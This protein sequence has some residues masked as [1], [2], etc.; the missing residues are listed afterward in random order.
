MNKTEETN[1]RLAGQNV[2]ERDYWLEKLA[3]E[4]VKTTFPYDH[5]KAEGEKGARIAFQLTGEVFD[6]LVKISNRSQPRLH[7]LL[8]AGWLML[9]NKYTG[10]SDIIVGVPTYKQDVEGELINTV[11]AV[12]SS[13]GG[14]MTVKELLMQVGKTMLEADKNQ[15]YP[16]ETLV[17]KLDIAGSGE[18][19][20]LFDLS[21][22]LEGIHEKRYLERISQNMVVSFRQ[23][24][25][26]LEG[27]VEYNPGL[28]R[29]ETIQRIV[30]HYRQLMQ[31]AL[32]NVNLPVSEVSILSAEER[33]QVCEEFNDN[34]ADYYRDKSIYRLVEERAAS[35]PGEE[36]LSFTGEN[37]TYGE[38]NG[39]AN[40]LAAELIE[41][42][43][44]ADDTVAIL[45]KRGPLMV[46]SILAIWKA[47]GAYI[48]LDVNYPPPRVL[49]ILADSGTRNLLASPGNIDPQLAREYGGIIIDPAALA[50]G[51]SAENISGEPV[52]NIRG[53][54]ET[55]PGNP[56]IEFSM[57]SLAYIIYTSGST[58]KPKGAMVE[59]A[60]M[61]N[62]MQSKINLLGIDNK[63]IVAQNASHTFDIS[64]WQFFVALAEGGK[65]FIYPDNVILDP[66]TFFKQVIENKITI[67]EVV[68]S[69]LSVML[70]VVE[71]TGTPAGV[72]GLPLPID[73]LLVTGEEVKPY[74]MA[75]WF[76]MYPQIKVVNAY[77][78]TEASDDITHYVMTG[79]AD[80][81]RERIPIGKTVQNL[82][83]H[84]VDKY[85]NLCPI[86]VV[87][88]LWVSGIGVGRGYLNRPELTAERFSETGR[89]YA[90]LP[91]TALQIK[92]FGGVGTALIKPVRDGRKGSDPPEA[93]FYRTG[94]L[95]RWLPDG[96]ID[97]LGRIDYQVKIRGY[98]IE[99][100]EIETCLATHQQVKEAI[101]IDRE[102][103][104]GKKYLCAYLVNWAGDE[105]LPNTPPLREYLLNTLPDYMVPA[106]FVI[107]KKI[108]LTPNGKVDRKALPKP[109]TG[110]GRGLSYISA[111]M[112]DYLIARLKGRPK[113]AGAKTTETAPLPPT[114]KEEK[115]TQHLLH[116]FNDTTAEYPRG[117]TL[118]QLFE[119]QVERTPG[120][121]ALTGHTL[122]AG[123]EELS[124]TYGEFNGR[125]NRLAR[126]LR[127]KGV[128]ADSIVG[129]MVERTVEMMVGIMGILKSGGAYMAISHT[130][131]GNRIEFM[132]GDS[133][134]QVL[135]TDETRPMPGSLAQ[136]TLDICE[137]ANYAEESRNLPEVNTPGNLAAVFYTSGSTGTPKGVLVEHSGLVNRI[138]WMQRIYPIGEHD[139]IMQKTSVIFDVSVWELFSWS[140][141]GAAL[142]LLPLGQ[143]GRQ[144]EVVE[145]IKKS[146]VTAMH[147]TPTALRPFLRHV[148]ETVS[149]GEVVTLKRVFASGEVLP[150]DLVSQ[151]NRLLYENAGTRLYNLYG[152]TEAS[153]EVTYYEC[154]TTVEQEK[155]PI[156]KPIDN[157]RLYIVNPGLEPVPEGTAGQ[158]CI[159]G[160]ALARGYLNRPGLTK[161]IF[162]ERPMEEGGRLYLTGDLARRM[163]NGNIDF[164]GRIDHQVQINGIRIELEEIE[165]ILLKHPAIKE[166]VVVARYEKKDEPYL[167]AF[168]VTAD[169]L[170]QTELKEY[171]TRD[172]PYYSIPARFRQLE[173]VPLTPT[174][175]V[176]RKVL[177]TIDLQPEDSGVEYL[178]PKTELE[179]HIAGIWEE[180]LNVDKVGLND[181]FFDIGGNS[182]GLIQVNNKLKEV[183]QQDIPALM[184]FEYP[185]IASIIKY[186]EKNTA[187]KETKGD[188]KEKSRIETKNKG[189][190]KMQQRRSRKKNARG[191][192]GE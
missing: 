121:P 136:L 44:R 28:Y 107:L 151:F 105:T 177:E 139:V 192:E 187:K 176:N 49:G 12:R 150:P 82:N 145:A 66:V 81:D 162:C 74:L 184:M 146:G 69:Y 157:T 54:G 154:S 119:E 152:P 155:I 57:N 102:D 92:A 86:G 109:A 111:E 112:L 183:L 9:L 170:Q 26:K 33:K 163:P 123:T 89:Q 43:V 140:F 117:K 180:I 16:I 3:G 134:I 15:N 93:R 91:G 76:E 38:V 98:R 31:S 129:I 167:C 132:C 32:K 97:F 143:G 13:V 99:L 59:H 68:P 182:L 6:G 8:T 5:R 108:P 171:L 10:N 70:D 52:E 87:G 191:R 41:K 190:S 40:R 60:G 36:A 51:E 21:V 147:F 94:D 100:G 175:K 142:Y 73:Y 39:A 90:R 1:K 53:R 17:Y 84:I 61:M 45:M 83:I 128:S 65:T 103:E 173:K 160:I 88:E 95:A 14:E 178:P 169:T 164:L 179:N 72:T 165:N 42:G 58:G 23:A 116:T 80:A 125:A 141:Y 186:L 158:L 115:D 25:T 27:E 20:P 181:N 118:Q 114:G 149:M 56:N 127:E 185:T 124:Y 37:Y 18:G 78:P 48:P 96:N 7:I 62:H 2:T 64:V 156:G 126:K 50:A 168:V 131:P 30:A 22:L 172:L 47:G 174:G 71:T 188:T 113:H 104:Q 122:A 106:H 166:S 161:E 137:P 133:N 35:G 29:E 148:E 11:L 153:V 120:R 4:L 135:V 79:P 130:Y 110:T 24:E 159:A 77:G 144:Q 19:F 138:N 55:A 34:P 75:R 85:N 189:K 46:I 67:L 63:S 101:V